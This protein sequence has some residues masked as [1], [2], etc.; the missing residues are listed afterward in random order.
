MA[1]AKITIL[2]M[3]MQV[4]MAAASAAAVGI[5]AHVNPWIAVFSLGLNF[6]WRNHDFACVIV[7]M[8]SAAAWARREEMWGALWDG[9]H[10]FGT[11]RLGV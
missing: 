1:N 10:E 7:L 11:R 6:A 3:L 4:L 9:L 2:L 5:L 8:S